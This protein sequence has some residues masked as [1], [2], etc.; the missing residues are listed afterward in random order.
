MRP[1]SIR[2]RVDHHLSMNWT[3]AE[4]SNLQNYSEGQV[5]KFHR[6][7]QGVDRNATLRVARVEDDRVIA[8]NARGEECCVA[9]KHA[10]C[11]EVYERRDIEVAPN[12][13]LLLMSNRSDSV[14]RATNGEYSGKSIIFDIH[15]PLCPLGLTSGREQTR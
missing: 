3:K 10:R 11:F 6:A 2:W 8:K 15:N 7:I 13:R 9:A 5:L 4:K 1:K 12:D 14:F